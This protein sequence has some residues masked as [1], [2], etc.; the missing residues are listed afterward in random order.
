[1]SA[2]QAPTSSV[3]ST[4]ADQAAALMASFDRLHI[5]ADNAGELLAL[6]GVAGMR[7]DTADDLRVE[8]AIHGHLVQ[9]FNVTLRNSAGTATYC[10]C[11]A[12]AAGAAEA[13]L[14]H[15]DDA[16]CGITEKPAEPDRL[17]LAAAHRTMR[18]AMPLD[19]AL[20]DPSLGRA[21]RSYARKHPVRR[22]TADFK[23]LAANDRD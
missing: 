23:S 7:G 10:T 8:L 22:P 21:L 16:P 19:A 18:I 6:A 1:M 2:M 15:Q 9:Q 14:E 3:D 4:M 13:A 17:A 12:D 5:A 20:D 11:A